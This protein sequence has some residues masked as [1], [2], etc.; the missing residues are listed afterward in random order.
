MGE[1]AAAAAT[2]TDDC[3]LRVARVEDV[4][5][6]HRVVISN[7]AEGVVFV[8]ANQACGRPTCMF[9]SCHVGLFHS[10]HNWAPVRGTPTLP[11]TG[12]VCSSASVFPAPTPGVSLAIK[13]TTVSLRNARVGDKFAIQ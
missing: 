8:T 11:F 2:G 3:I 10:L 1:P 5:V 7:G 9:Y 4:G 13:I 12:T 6:V